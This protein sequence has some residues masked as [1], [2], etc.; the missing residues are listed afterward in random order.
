M[1]KSIFQKDHLSGLFQELKKKQPEFQ[2]PELISNPNQ[3]T[4]SEINSR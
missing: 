4:F 1:R 2:N 3:I